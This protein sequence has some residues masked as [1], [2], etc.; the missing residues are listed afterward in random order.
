MKKIGLSLVPAKVEG[1]RT[2]WDVAV[3][4]ARGTTSE[5]TEVMSRFWYFPVVA[6]VVNVGNGVLLDQ[7]EL[8]VLTETLSATVDGR[9]VAEKDKFYDQPASEFARSFTE[10]FDDL[11]AAWAAI[12]E[13]RGL[14]ALAA[15]SRGLARAESHPNLNYWLHEYKVPAVETPTE[16]P[17]LSN[18]SQEAR[19]LV[20]GGVQL[21]ALSLRLK[22]GD[23]TAFGEAVL[24]ARPSA[25]SLMWSFVVT[26]ELTIHIPSS[27]GHLRLSS[28]AEAYVRGRHLLAGGQCDLAIAC[29]FQVARIYPDMGEIY[30]WIGHAFMRKG[31]PGCAADYHTKALQA[32][33]FPANM[34]QWTVRPNAGAK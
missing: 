25:E 23:L 12:T 2:Y 7:C 29:W 6:R 1:L 32:D 9:P 13:L 18:V 31:M 11:A 22:D 17:V 34:A 27:P 28:A 15:L 21:E 8:A 10:H 5:R 33:P 20:E 30:E 19:L 26:P 24:R 14:A 4:K 16:A 3:E